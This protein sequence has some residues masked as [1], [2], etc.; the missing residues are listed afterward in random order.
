[1][2]TKKLYALFD[3]TVHT[4]LN[5]LVFTNDGEATRWFTGIVNQDQPG[6]AVFHHYQ[7]F[8]LYNLGQMEDDSG[9]ITSTPKRIM[10]GAAVKDEQKQYTLEDLIA[11]IESRK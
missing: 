10:E 8:A 9:N 6:N 5:P 3:K 2:A 7:D 1:M 4:F 11:A